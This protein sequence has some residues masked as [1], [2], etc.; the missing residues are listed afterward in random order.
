M[1]SQSLMNDFDLT[2]D[3]YDKAVDRVVSIAMYDLAGQLE[4]GTIATL[5]SGCRLSAIEAMQTTKPELA[6]LFIRLG[7]ELMATAEDE[8]V[9]ENHVGTPSKAI[10]LISSLV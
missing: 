5:I 8:V 3:D 6:A 10:A 1:H 7:A 4:H 9:I 2:Q